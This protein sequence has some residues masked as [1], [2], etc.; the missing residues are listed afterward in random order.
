MHN[1]KYY[2][3]IY[4]TFHVRMHIHIPDRAIVLMIL[5][6]NGGAHTPNMAIIAGKVTP[7][8]SS[9]SMASQFLL[10]A[11]LLPQKILL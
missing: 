5:L 10:S 11:T 8:K 9:I 3:T 6:S 1:Y 7:C 2:I 4:S